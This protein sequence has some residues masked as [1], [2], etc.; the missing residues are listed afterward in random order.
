MPVTS[1]SFQHMHVC[2][3]SAKVIKLPSHCSSPSQCKCITGKK[4]SMIHVVSDVGFDMIFFSFLH[5]NRH[6]ITGNEKGSKHTWFWGDEDDGGA[7]LYLHRVLCFCSVCFFFS[8]YCSLWY[9][10]SLLLSS[11]LLKLYPFVFFCSLSSLPSPFLLFFF[12]SS[13][14]GFFLLAFIARGWECFW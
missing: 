6:H 11:V 2:M 13:L 7:V 3:N 12:F 9:F 5:I 10:K 8:P 1:L 14:F 4:K